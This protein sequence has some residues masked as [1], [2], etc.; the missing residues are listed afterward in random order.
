MSHRV[1]DTTFGAG[2]CPNR[3]GL[4]SHRHNFWRGLVTLDIERSWR[5]KDTTTEEGRG[6]GNSDNVSSL[7][8]GAYTTWLVMVP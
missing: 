6:R 7:S 4:V 3:G 2:K 8:A 5:L 1:I